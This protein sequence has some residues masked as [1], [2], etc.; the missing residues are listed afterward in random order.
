MET[1]V[2]LSTPHGES[3]IAVVRLSGPMC[4]PMAQSIFGRPSLLPR[5]CHHGSYRDKDGQILDSVLYVYFPQG[6]SYTGEEMLEI[7]THGNPFIVRKIIHDLVERG[8]RHAEPGEF[9]RRAFLNG[10]ID[11]CQAEA[12]A[13]L[14][15]A[16]SERDLKAAQRQLNGEFS[17]YLQDLMD[18]L[19][20]D[21]ALVEAFLDFPEEDLPEESLQNLNE[22]ISSALRT[23]ERLLETHRRRPPSEIR[24]VIAGPPNAGKSTL[25][26]ILL[27][28]ARALVSPTPGTTRDFIGESISLGSYG[29]RLVDTAGIRETSDETERQGIEKT[30]EQL[31]SADLI[32]LVL[33]GSQPIVEWPDGI[34]HFFADDRTLV[35]INKMDLPTVLPIP[36]P[37]FE[38]L[39]QR[40]VSLM[41]T[42][43]SREITEYLQRLCER[44]FGNND[45]ASFMVYDR[46]ADA[47]DEARQRLQSAQSILG[48]ERIDC[49][50]AELKE[51]IRALER[52]T[53]RVDYEKVLDLIFSR[54]CIGK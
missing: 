17:R 18:S 39:E 34:V 29:L 52:I 53:G 40:P 31:S 50:A 3:G 16:Q 5:H 23:M 27:G 22:E 38:H 12:V 10:K 13:D 46:H 36:V 6:H 1:I 21:L 35:L 32:L 2:A 37:Y 9:T 48:N 30:R 4:G 45:E 44:R 15:H 51:A 24:T 14:I 11:L 19:V 49:L 28:Q 25:F 33:D 20:K 43:S 26:N 54:F 7:S 8:G 47:L 41:N 42:S